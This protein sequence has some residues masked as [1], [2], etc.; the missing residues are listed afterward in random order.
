MLVA[1][2]SISSKQTKGTQHTLDKVTH[3]LNYCATHPEAVVRYHASD[4]ALHIHSDAS[5][6]SASEARSCI[7]G[8][9]F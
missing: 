4:M 2:G 5:Y 6:L 1:I 9:F 3:L 7:G 8:Y